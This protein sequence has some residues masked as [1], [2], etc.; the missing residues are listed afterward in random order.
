VTTH[1]RPIVIVGAGAA[2]T[3]AAIAA[4]GAGRATILLE[5]TRDGGRKILI[6]G[7]GRCNVLPSEL[8]P[9]RYFTGSSRNAMK[10][11][12]LSWPLAEQR[13][14]FEDEVGVPLAL[15]P[16]TGKLFPRSNRARDV[17][18]GLL[19]LA[20]SR[21][22]E[23]RF[24]TAVTGLGV[25]PDGGGWGVETADGETILA[26]AVVLATGGLSV[27][28]TGS[29]GTG[30]R[31]AGG[32]GHT[33]HDTYPALTPLTADP[34][35]HEDLAGVSLRV[36]IAVGASGRTP[37]ADGGFLFTHR[38]Y[39]GP[40]TLDVSHLSILARRAG[41]PVPLLVRWC[42]LDTAAWEA[43]LLETGPGGIGTLVR[44]HLPHRLA[45][46]LL[47]E[48]GVHPERTRSRLRREER[49]RLVELLARYPLPVTG[50]EGYRKAEVTGGGIPLEEVDPRTLESRRAPGL[51]L[52]GEMLDAFGPIG[53]Y[54]FAWAW[55][56][57]RAAGTGAA[58]HAGDTA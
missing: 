34:P 14:F 6:S 42:E 31:L 54:N 47:D 50:D 40:A 1:A 17:R 46:A 7:G 38:G 19:R 51:F 11:M 37:I 28:N 30:L 13:A 49:A 41:A 12:L 58:A 26:S 36:S 57:G 52:C 10:K 18:D 16:E 20:A 15:E 25:D 21:G 3:M 32:Q 9:S 5:R 48:A 29:D 53:G 43:L 33:L 39:S 23:L 27:P 2:G 4:A 24:E 44:R 55:A 22:A 45:D 8:S 56:T 35:V